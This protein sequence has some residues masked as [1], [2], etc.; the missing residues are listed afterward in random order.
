MS[1]RGDAEVTHMAVRL[2]DLFAGVPAQID[3]DIAQAPVPGKPA[4]YDAKLLKKLADKY[5]LDWTPVSFNDHVTLSTAATH[6]TTEMLREAVTRKAKENGVRGEIDVSFDN[7][8]TEL[9]LPT[10]QGAD[11]ALN[12][13]DYDAVSKR[14]RAEVAAVSAP[15][16]PLVSLTGR[17]AL[18]YRV[19]VLAHR[20][21]S[22]TVIGASDI[23]W[24]DVA[25]ERVNDSIITE[26]KQLIGRELRHATLEGELLRTNDVLPPRLV[27]RGSMVTMR[28]ENSFMSITAQ[29]RALQDGAVGETVRVMNLQSNRVIEGQVDSSGAVVV[30]TTRKLALA[31]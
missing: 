24:I 2:S 26:D 23:D 14:F 12:N 3:R 10:D 18:R 22:G 15:S 16:Q 30:V 28:I 11:I 29:G 7:R 17:I 19:P 9:Y 25:E 6:I 1:L 4:V 20:L 13:F 8:S 21:D 5:R 31:E 27:T